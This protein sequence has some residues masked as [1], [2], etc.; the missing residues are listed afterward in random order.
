MPARNSA[1]MEVARI[2]PQTIMRIEGG[3]MTASTAETAVIATEKPSSYP[4]LRCASMKILDW[5]AA[6]AVELPDIP[7]KKIDK[8]TLIWA[9]P[10]GKCPTIA[11]DRRT[12]RSVMPPTFMRLAVSKKNG[13]ASKMKLLYALKVSW[14]RTSGVSLGSIR[15]GGRQASASAKATGTRNVK[16]AKKSPKRSPAACPGERT[17]APGITGPLPAG[18]AGSRSRVRPGKEARRDPPEARRCG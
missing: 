1:P 2:P 7:A 14:T 13:T 16:N 5:L 3:M 12:R 15:R 11:R 6:S 4:S 9:S 18:R 10:P 8:T 17:A